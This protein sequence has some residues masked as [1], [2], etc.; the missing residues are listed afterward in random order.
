MRGRDGKYPNSWT[1]ITDRPCKCL[2]YYGSISYHST[3]STHTQL[4]QCRL[5]L[6]ISDQLSLVGILQSS[7]GNFNNAKKM[8]QVEGGTKGAYFRC[9]GKDEKIWQS[10][11]TTIHF[12]STDKSPLFNPPKHPPSYNNN[13]KKKNTFLRYVKLWGSVWLSSQHSPHSQRLIRSVCRASFYG[14]RKLI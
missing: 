2:S 12:E 1:I 6:F 13:K 8:K 14:Q 5:S 3:R 11:G 10:R 4:Y 9:K 7:N